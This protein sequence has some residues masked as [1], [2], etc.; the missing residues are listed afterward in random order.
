MRIL[1]GLW[2]LAALLVLLLALVAFLVIGSRFKD[3]GVSESLPRG[4]FVV[5]GAV[6]GIGDPSAGGP[7]SRRPP[8]FPSGIP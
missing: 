3:I 5:S 7:D 8:R 2:F 4:G 1:A 6:A